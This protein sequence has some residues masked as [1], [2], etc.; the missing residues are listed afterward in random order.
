[1]PESFQLPESDAIN[2]GRTEVFDAGIFQHPLACLGCKYP[3]QN[4]GD[5]ARR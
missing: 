3:P 2:T 1:M 5:V 4:A